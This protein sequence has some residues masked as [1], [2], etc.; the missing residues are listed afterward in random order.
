MYTFR[1]DLLHALYARC[2]YVKQNDELGRW[3]K[4]QLLKRG[5]HSHAYLLNEVCVESND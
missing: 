3:C 5:I 4:E 1:G 2:V